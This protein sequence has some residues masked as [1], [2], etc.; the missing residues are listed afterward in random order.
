MSCKKLLFYLIFLCFYNLCTNFHNVVA[1][2][3]VDSNES[4]LYR[5][6]FKFNDKLCEEH[7]TQY[8]EALIGGEPK[9]W[10]MRSK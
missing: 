4:S 2:N 5:S 3:D 9:E 8:A 6:S 10:A 7:L 1:V